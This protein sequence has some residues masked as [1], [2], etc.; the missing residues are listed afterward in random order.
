MLRRQSTGNL[1]PGGVGARAPV[2]QDHRAPMP[3][4]RTRSETSPR[5]N[6]TD[7]GERIQPTGH[8]KSL[9]LSEPRVALPLTLAAEQRAPNQRSLE[10]HRARA[11]QASS[12]FG[13]SY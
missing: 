13:S 5:F 8:A 9:T 4:C 12:N 11:L 6:T 7:L 3:P 1:V 2:Q 10:A